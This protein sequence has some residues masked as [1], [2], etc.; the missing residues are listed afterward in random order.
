MFGID[1]LRRP[2][3][4]RRVGLRVDVDE[5]RRVAGLGDARGDVDGGRGLADAALLV[6]DRVDGA[7][8]RQGT[9]RRSDPG[10]VRARTARLSLDVEAREWPFAGHSRPRAGIASGVVP[11]FE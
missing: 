10:D 3:A 6:R 1:V 4:D 7:H 11:T 8:R 9:A 5:Q 2:E